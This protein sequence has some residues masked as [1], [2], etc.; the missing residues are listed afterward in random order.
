MHRSAPIFLMLALV[1]GCAAKPPVVEVQQVK[2]PVPVACKEPVPERPVMPTE[3]LSPPVTLDSFVQAAM[4]EIER[5]EGYEQ[6]LLTGLRACTA[7]V[8]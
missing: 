5:R 1:A 4:A 8:Y 2:V 7:P 6:Q 3:G